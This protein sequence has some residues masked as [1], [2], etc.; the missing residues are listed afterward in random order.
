MID[1]SVLQSLEI[2]TNISEPK[3][4]D[5]LF[6]LLNQ[7]ETPMGSRMLRSNILQPPTRYET[8]IGPRY[9]ALEEFIGAEEMFHD[10]RKSVSSP[11]HL[12][13]RDSDDDPALGYFKDIERVLTKVRLCGQDLKPP[14]LTAE[15]QIIT[16]SPNAKIHR[17]E[18]QI[19]HVLTVKAFLESVPELHQALSG[20]KSAL[21]RKIRDICQ[22]HVTLP[23]LNRV[24]AVIEA[25]ATAMSS[26]LDM[27]NAR[28]FAV[29]SGINGM[30]DVARQT[31]KEL[32]TEIH[33]H[34]EDIDSE[35]TPA[36]C[37][38]P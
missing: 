34:V 24:R 33:L 38:S 17:A 7:T 13:S 21:L 18:E 5:S 27:R 3:S 2:V 15:N 35:F 12:P 20:C 6:G 23:I 19:N 37:A 31:Y 8:F 16:I 29:R 32:T 11:S 4:R 28:T 10:V 9:D 36:V 26:P 30:L 25:D 1:V 14:L 22:P